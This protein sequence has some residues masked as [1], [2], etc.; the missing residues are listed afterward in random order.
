MAG[1]TLTYAEDVI[2]A[3]PFMAKPG[4]TEA[5]PG[6]FSINMSNTEEIWALQFNITLPE[7]F[8]LL[9][10]MATD[11]NAE[12]MP[13]TVG[14]GG[15][16]TF[17]H[18][19]ATAD[20]QAD[21]S[22]LIIIATT[23][24]DR[25]IGNSGEIIKLFFT[26]E[27][28]VAPG[29]YPIKVDRTVMTIT[30]SSD[31]QPGASYS[32]VTVSEDGTTNSLSTE[33]EIDLSGMT[34]DLPSFVVEKLNADIASNTSLRKLNL[35]GVTS[36]G[37]DL[38]VPENAVWYTSKAARLNRT[39]SSSVKCT[40]CL[41]FGIPASTASALGTFYQFSGIEDGKVVME[42]VT[43]DLAANTPYIF[44]P[45]DGQT[46]IGAN[47]ASGLTVSFGTSPATENATA[48]FTFK[49][50]YEPITWTEAP[51]GIYGFSVA[52]AD[53]GVSGV[54]AG[55]F[56]LC[57]AGANIPAYRA[58]LEYTGEGTLSGTRGAGLP[59]RMPIIW[60]SGAESHITGIETIG[61]AAAEAGTAW[62][63]LN[64]QQYAGKPAAKGIYV[65][66]GKKVI[67]K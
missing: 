39:F 56:V 37:A 16:R 34:G 58:Y 7:G 54:D 23:Q 19:N 30:G 27:S 12:R 40:V 65:H 5:D 10:P 43:G 6:S 57:G 33:A 47:S 48:K 60:R 62:Y 42:A 52:E 53:G 2:Q 36:L 3:V 4:L 26:T 15:A 1:S 24:D 20:K 55:E 41:P 17:K 38:V 21:G 50:T 35:S 28:T 63:G 49:G 32:Y 51:T 45:A 22:W 18:M 44:S 66:N 64:G 59:A 25:I 67:V 14:R 8:E 9:E 61:Q 13:N 29:V 31:I 11:Y 46:G